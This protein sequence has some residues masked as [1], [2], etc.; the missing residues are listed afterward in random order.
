MSDR[1]ASIFIGSASES[2]AIA[3]ALQENL[4]RDCEAVVWDQD[5]FDLGEAQFD[6]LIRAASEF[7]FAIFVASGDDVTTRRG[8]ALAVPRDNV[9]LEIGL[10]IGSLGR[11]HVFVI[12]PDEAE[13]AMPTDMAG[14]TIGR[15]KMHGDGRLVSAI[16]PLSRR[17][18]ERIRQVGLRA[19][20]VEAQIYAAALCYKVDDNG[21]QVLLVRSSRGRWVFPKGRVFPGEPTQVAALRCAED[22]GGVSARCEIH[23]TTLFRHLKEDA[24]AEQN[25]VTHIVRMTREFP[26][27]EE[28]RTPE[29]FTFDNAEVALKESR[30]A[31]YAEEFRSTLRWARE[32]IESNTVTAREV[33]GVIP[34]RRNADGEIEVLLINSRTNQNWVI[35]KGHRLDGESFS[36]TAQREAAEEAGISG[37]ILGDPIGQYE[38]TRLSINYL[39]TVFRFEVL[40]ESL[41]WNEMDVRKRCWFKLDEALRLAHE[42][43]LRTLIEKAADATE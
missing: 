42:S 36:E 11:E 30:T 13:V 20:E 26:V 31:R 39:V 6:S 29:W 38:Y 14:I 7:D 41:F 33:A 5:I 35:P 27:D 3:E 43:A 37:R 17:I 2:R 23:E 32:T 34:I 12:A 19:R 9:I 21:L 15:F 4:A 1:S 40:E 16:A 22:E 8:Q 25:V 24:G 10:F 18:I 28:F